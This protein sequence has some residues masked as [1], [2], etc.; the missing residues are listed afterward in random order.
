MPPRDHRM[1]SGVGGREGRCCRRHSF[2][3]GWPQGSDGR[4][5]GARVQGP[6]INSGL[7]S[8]ASNE[9]SVVAVA[10]H[11]TVCVGGEAPLNRFRVECVHYAH[12]VDAPA[13]LPLAD[14]PAHL[15]RPV[16]ALG[17]RDDKSD[18]L[19]VRKHPQGVLQHGCGEA[20]VV[21]PQHLHVQQAPHPGV[22]AQH[23]HRVSNHWKPHHTLLLLRGRC[24]Q[25]FRD[26]VADLGRAEGPQY[27]PHA[28]E[29]AVVRGRLRLLSRGA[30]QNGLEARPLMHQVE[31]LPHV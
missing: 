5:C 10:L 30:H 23:A 19:L 14:L 22:A 28:G 1:G 11:Y 26:C 24:M 3:L 4:P 15:P 13:P 29:E 21:A 16:G 31:Q 12:H 17:A 18:A 2:H 8:N 6:V 7:A 25:L 27:R 9:V 20:R